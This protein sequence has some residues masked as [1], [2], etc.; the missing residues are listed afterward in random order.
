MFVIY[1]KK[2]KLVIFSILIGTLIFSVQTMN[3]ENDEMTV[4]TVSVPVSGK[5]V[6]LDA[7]HGSPDEGAESSNGITEA[8]INLEITLKIQ[9]LLEM[10]GCNVIL[11][12]SDE[13]GIY[14][15]DAETLREKKNSDLK[16]R[17]EIANESNADIFVSIH[18]NKIEEE[19]YWGWQTFFKSS[20]ESSIK[21]ANNIQNSLNEVI[22]KNNSRKS[23]K[24][25][26]VYLIKNVNIPISIVECGFLS[27]SEEERLL[28]D[29]IY[30]DKLAWG[31]YLGINNYFHN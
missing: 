30:Q 3:I 9:K 18:L 23:L 15:I 14:E 16:N 11:T 22:E 25:D 20:N 29:D 12:R 6:I 1:A 26:N 5:T 7:G 10:S 27:N 19:K 24:L 2:I 17:L 21:L 13:N 31:I 8:S 4:E 28:Q